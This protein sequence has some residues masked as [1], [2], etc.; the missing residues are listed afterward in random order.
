MVMRGVKVSR[1]K[2]KTFPLQSTTRL[3]CGFDSTAQQNKRD[4]P[5]RNEREG[6]IY[7]GRCREFALFLGPLRRLLFFRR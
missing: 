4:I 2:G 3:N 6:P 7:L 5:D 1:Q